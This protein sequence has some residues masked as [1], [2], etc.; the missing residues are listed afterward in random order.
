MFILNAILIIIISLNFA[1]DYLIDDEKANINDQKLLALNKVH[2]GNAALVWMKNTAFKPM[3]FYQGALLGKGWNEAI[4]NSYILS[5]RKEKVP[6]YVD[7]FT[8]AKMG[9][10]RKNPAHVVCGAS[11]DTVHDSKFFF[12]IIKNILNIIELKEKNEIITRAMEWILE[13][14]LKIKGPKCIA[15][16]SI[17]LAVDFFNLNRISG[18]KRTKNEKINL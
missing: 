12:P 1:K 15:T 3:H 10:Y 11:K 4:I 9:F 18:L 7:Y 13:G 14:V 2:L 6:V 5:L 16:A 8:N 17:I